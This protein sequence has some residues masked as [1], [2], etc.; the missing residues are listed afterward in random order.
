[1]IVGS[2]GATDQKRE[3]VIG[4]AV[5]FASRIESATKDAGAPLL[6]SEE[7][8][9]HVRDRVEIGVQVTTP[10][11]GKR[12]EHALFEVTGLN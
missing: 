6:I 12:G 2:M 5:N 7:V 11:K 10:V 9:K 8:Y 1:V 4:D 3:M